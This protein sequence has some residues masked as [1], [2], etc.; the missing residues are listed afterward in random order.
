MPGTEEKLSKCLLL[1]L[2]LEKTIVEVE[3]GD[4]LT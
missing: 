1:L 3:D 4:Y 2:L